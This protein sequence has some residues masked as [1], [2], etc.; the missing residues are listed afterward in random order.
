MNIRSL[1]DDANKSMERYDSLIDELR[2]Q[3]KVV[4]YKL[5]S[6]SLVIYSDQMRELELRR[7]EYRSKWYT[8]KQICENKN[9]LEF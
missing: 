6:S 9:L 5:T 4:D 2:E 3:I 1:R 7:E 8:L